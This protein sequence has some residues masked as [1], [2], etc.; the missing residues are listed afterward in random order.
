MKGIAKA[1]LILFMISFIF[2][3]YIIA[4]VGLA[5]FLFQNNVNNE[6]VPAQEV[7][8]IKADF[9]NHEGLTIEGNLRDVSAQCV[10]IMSQIYKKNKEYYNRQVAMGILTNMLIKA[11]SDVEGVTAEPVTWEVSEE[12][13]MD[14]TE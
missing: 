14:Y 2:I 8:M 12:E 5:Q 4:G 10:I 7:E 9:K 13:K 11:V 6:R 3:L 1:L